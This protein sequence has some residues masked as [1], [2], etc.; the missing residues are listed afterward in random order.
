MLNGKGLAF[1]HCVPCVP[2]QCP[3]FMSIQQNFLSIKREG[4]S[5]LLS[6]ALKDYAKTNPLCK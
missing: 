4:V 3:V 5:D 1:F 6:L 2:T